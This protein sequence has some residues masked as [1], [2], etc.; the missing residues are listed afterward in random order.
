[1]LDEKGQPRNLR[2]G[3]IVDSFATF[4]SGLFGTS[5]GTPYI[6]SSAG[7][8]AGGRTGLTSVATALCFLPCLFLAPI[9]AMVPAMMHLLAL[10]SVALLLI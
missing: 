8:E 3:L 9:A 5:P 10:I 6:E 4:F 1:M 7:I 2:Q